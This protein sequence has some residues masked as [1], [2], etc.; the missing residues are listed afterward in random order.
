MDDLKINV[1][2]K[3]KQRNNLFVEDMAICCTMNEYIEKKKVNRG[4]SEKE[5]DFSPKM[6]TRVSTSFSWMARIPCEGKTDINCF[7]RFLIRK[8][9]FSI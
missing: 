2:T 5:R 4:T 9:K 3:L 6:P 8:I 7:S 1:N